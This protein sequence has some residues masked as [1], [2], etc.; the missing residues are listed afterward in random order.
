MAGGFSAYFTCHTY[1][2]RNREAKMEQKWSAEID[3]QNSIPQ[4]LF[5]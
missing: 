2:G 3:Q 4:V 5:L 1:F